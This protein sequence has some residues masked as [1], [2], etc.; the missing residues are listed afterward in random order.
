MYVAVT[1]RVRHAVD[2]FLEVIG[3]APE[4]SAH[5]V[6]FFPVPLAL[7]LVFPKLPHVAC[8]CSSLLARW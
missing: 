2:P 5:I 6:D 1:H 3:A 4:Q 8:P 7:L